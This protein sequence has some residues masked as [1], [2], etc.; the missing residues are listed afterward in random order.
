MYRNCKREPMR[1]ESTSRSYAP[2]E[3]VWPNSKYITK[4]LR[5][6]INAFLVPVVVVQEE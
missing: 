3:K 4:S 5:S 1:K 6:Q 2:G